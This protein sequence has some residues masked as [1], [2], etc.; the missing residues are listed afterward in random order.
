MAL[1]LKQN[2]KLSQQLV[3]TPQLRQAIKLLQLS[4][5][6]LVETVKQEILENPAL[7]KFRDSC[8][9][10]LEA[11]RALA[12]TVQSRPSD[13]WIGDGSEN[14]DADWL[15]SSSTNGVSSELSGGG[16]IHD[17]LPP[18]EA[19]LSSSASLTD[20]LEWQLGLQ[21][22][23]DAERSAAIRIINNLNEHGFLTLSLEEVAERCG[24]EL[25]DA[26][27]AQM[28]VQSLDPQGCGS[29][30]V[31]ECLVLQAN[32]SAEDPFVRIL[33]DHLPDLEANY[34]G[35]ARALDIHLE[36]V[37]EY[38]KMIHL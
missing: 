21:H 38:H 24:V 26:E 32:F 25:D 30:G 18:I 22:C 2:L 23:T 37:I 5:L 8:V 7:R 12:Q 16:T 19:N 20:H 33:E 4:H 3:I 36:D 35:I 17:D 15:G 9:R 28:I 27:G 29:S 13:R 11:E 10:N 14:T 6:D 34:Q 1:E 31:V